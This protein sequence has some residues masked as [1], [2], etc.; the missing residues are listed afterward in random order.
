M[1]NYIL[2]MLA[3][4]I[5]AGCPAQP[6][7]DDDAAKAVTDAVETGKLAADGKSQA[8]AFTAGDEPYRKDAINDAT[9]PLSQKVIYFDYNSSSIKE[10]YRDLVTWHGRYL[11]SNKD[12]KLRLE[13][14]TDE[15][16][17][18]EYNIALADSRALAVSRML[19]FQGAT[20]KQIEVI[21]Y[22]EEKPVAL[23]HNEEAWSKNRRVQLVYEAM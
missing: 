13:G 12:M 8:T 23:E 19:M 14:H 7:K 10:E 11:A 6:T 4:L 16:G 22:G 20:K 1:R 15:R 2:L 18:R 3:V 9:S 21:S 5:L 17:S